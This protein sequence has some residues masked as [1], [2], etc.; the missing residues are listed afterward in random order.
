MS[1]QKSTR[2]LFEYE[3]TGHIKFVQMFCVLKW[4]HLFLMQLLTLTAQLHRMK[5]WYFIFWIKL[6]VLVAQNMDWY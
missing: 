5:L 1:G 6:S 4:T 3:N 2:S